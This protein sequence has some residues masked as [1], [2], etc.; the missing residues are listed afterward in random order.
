MRRTVVK[1]ATERNMTNKSWPIRGKSA[2]LS[3]SLTITAGRTNPR[4]MPSCGNSV[5][6]EV[7]SSNIYLVAEDPNGCGRAHLM[8]RE[9]SGSQLGRDPEN[10]D[11]AGSHH[12]L[13]CEGQPPLTRPSAQHLNIK[14]LIG[15]FFRSFG[16]VWGPLT[17]IR[18]AIHSLICSFSFQNKMFRNPSV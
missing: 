11:L 9:P 13:T 18:W 4:A 14:P 17:R 15:D 6:R 1:I 5:R 2:L 16:L 3:W 8:R 7:S 12:S 10:E